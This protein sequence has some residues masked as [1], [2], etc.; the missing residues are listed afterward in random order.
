[1]NYKVEDTYRKMEFR[2]D[3]YNIKIAAVQFTI[4]DFNNVPVFFE[5]FGQRFII[6][7]DGYF[8]Y[9][10]IPTTRG[11]LRANVGDWLYIGLEEE[12]Q[13]ITDAKLKMWFRDKKEK[14]VF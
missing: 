3:D 7:G 2:N 11:V 10:E 5:A 9:I 6:K 14:A 4:K 8:K 1:M 12:L 13:P